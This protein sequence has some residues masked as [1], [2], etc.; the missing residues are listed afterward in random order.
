MKP[1]LISG[2]QPSG[3]LHLGNYLGALKNFV[4]LQNSNKYAC[5]F[6]IADLHSLTEPFTPKEK[7]RQILE[8]TSDYLAA[9]LNPKKSVIFQQSQISAHSELAW[10]LN[11]LTP[12]GELRRMTQFKD[13]TER[14]TKEPSDKLFHEFMRQKSDA[15]AEKV[16]V[17]LFT[18]PTLMAAD[19]LLYDAK[20]VP[21][22][23][24]QDQH[25]EF[26]RT[27]ARKFNQNFGKTFVEP[28]SLHTET[29]RL[30][31]VGNPSKKMS[32]SE[33]ATCLFLD[34]SPETIKSKIMKAVTD[35]DKEIKYHPESKPAISNLLKIYAS[36]SEDGIPKLE[37]Q[38][39]GKTYAEF[40]SS[41]AKLIVNHLAPYRQTKQN[42]KTNT[43]HLKTI[44]N[45]GSNLARKISSKK[46]SEVKKRI[47]LS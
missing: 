28:K 21:V 38:F 6:F 25:L 47:G 4:D 12:M 2:I 36:L 3:K 46:I 37:K 18:Y 39:H 8:L 10:I 15:G 22:G 9:G 31:S 13:K 20:F 43:S 24:D 42:L 34:D 35:S 5:Y 33:P 32:K 11:T 19:I 41:L 26:T 1:L 16:N 14:H 44:L 45:S 29:P 30:M 7:Q 27:L 40:K 23:N 17:G